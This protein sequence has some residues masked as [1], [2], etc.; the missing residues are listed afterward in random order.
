MP[1]NGC[2]IGAVICEG[3]SAR[4]F[5]WSSEVTED[6]DETLE[7]DTTHSGAANN[8]TAAQT[9]LTITATP[10]G[11]PTRTAMIVLSFGPG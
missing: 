11:V 1:A 5:N 7:A 2:L 6:Y 8:Y 9:G 3:G 4:T 10:S